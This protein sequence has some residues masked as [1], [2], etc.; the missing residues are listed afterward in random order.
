[1]RRRY[2]TGGIKKQRGRWIGMWWVDGKRKS[3]VL[4]LVK[5]MSKTRARE[6]INQIVA[7]ENAKR[8]SKRFGVLGNLSSKSISPTTAAN[9]RHQHGRAL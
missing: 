6:A 1:M 7:A 2:S 4:G 5:D 8:D 9:G 3:K